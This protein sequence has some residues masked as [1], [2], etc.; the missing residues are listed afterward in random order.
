MTLMQQIAAALSCMALYTILHF[1]WA[2]RK[3]IVKELNLKTR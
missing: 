1:G 3:S 2:N